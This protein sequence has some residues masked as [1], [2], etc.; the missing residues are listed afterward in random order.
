MLPALPTGIA[1]ASGGAAE[2]VADLEGGR[3]LALDPVRVDRV[4]ELDR[5]L[6][7]ELADDPSA[8]SKLPRSAITRA[9]CISAWASLPI[10]I[11]PSGTI[12][13][14]RMPGPGRVG[15]GARSGVP[16]R[17]ADHGL[18]AR[19]LRPRDRHRHPPVLE[20]AGRVRALELEQ[21]PGA[22]PLGEHRRLDQ[23]RRALVQ[24]DDRIVRP[25]ASQAVPVALDQRARHA[26]TNSSSITRIARG[27]ERRKSSCGDL[28]E[29]RVEAGLGRLV[30]D[31]HQAGVV[32]VAALDDAS[33]EISLRPSTSAIRASTPWRSATSRWR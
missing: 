26:Q 3:L 32:A 23:R 7:R 12:T 22:D 15:G 16:G 30:H 9:P 5:V 10:A 1:S 8:S 28:V 6:L 11:L 17:G 20:A 19:A 29:G 18:G 14:P 27:G 33:T 31:H 24:G 25:R 2:L 21:H 13:A 4:D